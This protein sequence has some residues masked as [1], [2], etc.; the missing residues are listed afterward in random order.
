MT[1]TVQQIRTLERVTKLIGNTKF[2]SSRYFLTVPRF[3]RN[4]FGRRA[5]SVGGPMAWNSLPDSL[6]GIHRTAAVVSGVI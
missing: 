2:I 1:S 3:R 4:K 6:R 5:F